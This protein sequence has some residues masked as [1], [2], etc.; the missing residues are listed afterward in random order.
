[1]ATEGVVAPIVEAPIAGA[2]GPVVPAVTPAPVAGT[3]HPDQAKWDTERAGFLKDLQAER[4]SRQT[5]ESQA[6][7]HQRDLEVER[8]RVRALS[9][10]E[11]PTEDQAA[12]AAI[13]AHFA[14][15][16]PHLGK[17]TAEDVEALLQVKAQSAQWQDSADA[18]WRDKARMMSSA[19]ES[20]IAKE[21]G[22]DLTP[23]QV[24]Q[25]QQAY[26]ARA[27]ADPAFLARHE[28]GDM[29]L[30]DEF[31]TEFIEDWFEP[32]RRKVTQ[33]QL[34]QQPRVPGA[35]DRSIPGQEGVKLD[36]TDSKAVEDFLLAGRKS[37]GEGF[38]RR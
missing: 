6:T 12:E 17:L 37:R 28:R 26:I 34:R 15:V 35:K 11:T 27:E 22:G 29:K 25:I 20:K 32:A 24:K 30:V 18:M 8:K 1:M 16:F 31:A 38:G 36:V 21:L 33:Q 14:K 13:K 23:R 10:L 3:P 4:K 19:I 5:F 2:S 9:G 7:A